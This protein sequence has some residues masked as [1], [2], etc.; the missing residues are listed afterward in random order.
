MLTPLVFH[1][2]EAL[3]LY[4]RPSRF[5]LN[6]AVGGV[7]YHAYISETQPLRPRCDWSPSQSCASGTMHVTYGVPLRRADLGLKLERPISAADT[8]HVR[9]VLEHS[10]FLSVHRQMNRQYVLNTLTKLII[11]DGLSSNAS[12]GF[13]AAA[14]LCLQVLSIRS[15]RAKPVSEF[16][17]ESVFSW[18]ICELNTHQSL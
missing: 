4:M 16:N 17:P 13:H 15:K 11:I 18:H 10:P 3:I 5:P 8:M 14:T 12:T 7:H 2:T 1:G 6:R 9:T